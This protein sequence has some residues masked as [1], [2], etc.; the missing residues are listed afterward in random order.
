MTEK[1]SSTVRTILVV[2]AIAAFAAVGV[3]ALLVNIMEHKQEARNPF[4]RVVE[5]DDDT[6]D[7]AVWG[8]NFPIQYDTYKRTV[9]M[10]RTKFGGSEA[11][12]RTPTEKDPRTQV[13]TSKIEEDPR[14]KRMWLGY[15]FAVD[16]R[17]ERGHA[18]ML[19]DQTFTER[20]QV[21]K[22]PG[23]CMNCHASTYVA[24][25]KLGNGDIVKGFEAINQ[26][27]YFDA[28]KHVKHPVAC[29][30]CHDSKTMALRV[31]RP[32]FMEG[33]RAYK[34]SQG[35]ADYD[36][37]TM[38][39]RQEMR[40]YVCGQCHVEYYFKGAEKRLTFPW[41]KGLKAD[42]I[43][44]Y[45]DEVGFK[46]WTHAETGA[47]NL[48]A[49]HPEFEMHNQGIHARSGVACADCHMP[50]TKVGAMKV[51]D[52]HVR[53]PLLNINKACQTCHRWS[54]EEL[55]ARAETIQSRHMEMRNLA[56]DA[57][58]SLIDDLKAA[59]EAGK[60]D[61]ELAVA[62]DF[63]RRASFLLDFAEAENSTG[64]H[65][66]QEGARVLAQSID[67]SRKGQLA[68]RGALPATPQPLQKAGAPAAPKAPE[69]V[70]L[71]SAR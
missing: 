39:T 44:A 20:Q 5:L 58:M 34:A 48:K 16:F 26:M 50:Y 62:R 57:L 29:I 13:T 40:T 30:D 22:Q 55:K 37:N 49:Q 9:D 69:K 4:F 8:K 52:H 51:S 14:L 38:A 56:M 17:E 28:R 31:T 1:K 23:T 10:V 43:L 66:P 25:K 32:A 3:T 2:A 36:V 53:S 68:V 24:M 64:F 41:H 71:L 12:P 27:P 47:P 67:A 63:Q 42:E 15:A 59:K 61:E 7:P 11:L 45:Y 6:E 18:Y 21:V 46:D 35:V 33:I 19:D 65:A 70:A 60:S 54:E